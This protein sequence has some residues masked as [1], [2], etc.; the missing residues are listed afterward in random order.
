MA[1]HGRAGLH[2]RGQ[3][4]QRGR[5]ALAE[6]PGGRHEPDR[7][8]R[9]R[10][11]ARRRGNGGA[12]GAARPVAGLRPAAAVHDPV[13]GTARTRVRQGHAGR[14][15]PH[16]AGD[17]PAPARAEPALSPG[18]PDRGHDPRHRARGARHRIADLLFALQHRAHPDRGGAG[19]HN[20]GGEVR[21]L[22]R[23]DH[24]RRAGAVHRLHDHRDRVA[25]Q[26]P[27]RGQR[28][29]LRGAHQGGGLAAELRNRQ[30]LQQRRLRGPALRRE[31]GKTA[32]GAPQEP[33]HAVAAQHR[34]ADDHR[35]R[36]GGDAVARHPGRG[37]RPHDAGRPGDG[38]RFHDPAV[39]PAELPGR[40]VP[41]DQAEPHGP[42]QDVR[43][44]GAR[45][46]GGRPTRRPAARF[47]T[48]TPSTPP[49]VSRT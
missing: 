48:A 3:A 23:L 4:R 25:H 38:Q 47:R 44:D 15:T 41:R 49:S 34:P 31:P 9:D 10:F 1:R 5:A 35:R 12:D 24:H 2:G 43:A 16:R 6:E 30:V 39:H 13:H 27:P 20:P 32:S 28:V 26:V 17:L 7:R 19:A 22:V 42:G 37:G 40:A 29:R 8:P 36:P 33:D 14:G 21:C 18:A 45:T 11:P 46:R